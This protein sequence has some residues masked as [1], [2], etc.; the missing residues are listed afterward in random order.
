MEASRQIGAVWHC[1][2]P[3]SYYSHV[4]AFDKVIYSRAAAKGN[5]LHILLQKRNS[6]LNQQNTDKNRSKEV[7]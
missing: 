6:I 2:S 3:L 7:A 1:V 5:F 4:Y